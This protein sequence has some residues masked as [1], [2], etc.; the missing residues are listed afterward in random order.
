M[1]HEATLGDDLQKDA[2]KNMHST[3]GEAIDM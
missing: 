3:V 1:I 2:I